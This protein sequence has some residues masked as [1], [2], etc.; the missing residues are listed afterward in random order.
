MTKN[1]VLLVSLL[2]NLFCVNTANYFYN[3]PI[4][5]YLCTVY[6]TIFIYINSILAKI[7]TVERTIFWRKNILISQINH[8]LYIFE[9]V[10]PLSWKSCANCKLHKNTK[11]Y[12]NFLFQIGGCPFCLWEVGVND[13]I[14]N[15]KKSFFT[16]IYLKGLFLM[17]K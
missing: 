1:A 4:Y 2:K 3:I 10:Y 8:N 5:S 9:M 16:H 15:L 11:K 17:D 13:Q 7:S 14:S 12:Q 6:K